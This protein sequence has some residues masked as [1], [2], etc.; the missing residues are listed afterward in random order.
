[1]TQNPKLKKPRSFDANLIV[2]GAV[3]AGVGRSGRESMWPSGPT[4]DSPSAGIVPAGRVPEG[5]SPPATELPKFEMISQKS[6]PPSNTS[7]IPRILTRPLR[8]RWNCQ[9]R[10]DAAPIGPRS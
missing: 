9:P 8:I 5:P 1:M 10:V 2:I 6:P 4:S 7:K 3:S